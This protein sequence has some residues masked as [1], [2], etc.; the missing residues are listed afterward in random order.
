MPGRDWRK[1][2]GETNHEEIIIA[3]FPELMRMVNLEIQ[4]YN[5]S[6]SIS[7]NKSILR[8][9]LLNTVEKYKFIRTAWKQLKKKK[10]VIF[11]E[12]IIRMRG[13]LP[14]API[15]SIKQWDIFNVLE[16]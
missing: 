9:V 7:K 12:M 10:M 2:I 13:S 15:K 11:R 16:K 5:K 4:E 1:E 14:T 8:S 3:N 6:K